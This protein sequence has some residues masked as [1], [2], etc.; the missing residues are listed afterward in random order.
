MLLKKSLSQS[1]MRFYHFAGRLST[2]TTPYID[3]N[4]EGVVFLEAKIDSTLDEFDLYSE[5][6]EHP[7][8]Y[9]A[10]NMVCYN[11]PH[12]TSLVG[13]QI[14]HFACGGLA[15]A[16]SLSHLV[17]DGCTNVSFLNYWGSVARYGSPDHKEEML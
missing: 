15:V 10:D 9:F 6:D 4:D 12:I 2:H 14:N 8:R 3:C 5:L 1:L 16:V 11:S 17:S 13:V 7:E